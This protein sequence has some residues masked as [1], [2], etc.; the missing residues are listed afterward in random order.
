MRILTAAYNTL[1][2]PRSRAA[3]DRQ[4]KSLP[5]NV[6]SWEDGNDDFFEKNAHADEVRERAHTSEFGRLDIER[7]LAAEESAERARLASQ[8]S[9]DP[10]KSGR[11][12]GARLVQAALIASSVLLA[13]VIILV[14]R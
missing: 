2:D 8:R 9:L 6:K 11:T 12:P 1:I 7:M 3:Y 10:V 13:V 14:A 4:L 5:V